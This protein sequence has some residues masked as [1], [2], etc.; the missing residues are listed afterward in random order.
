[1]LYSVINLE[2]L[3]FSGFLLLQGNTF[4]LLLYKKLFIKT[5]Y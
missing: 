4:I 1:M 5:P 2:V 3:S